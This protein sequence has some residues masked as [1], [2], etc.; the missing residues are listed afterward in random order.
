M[1]TCSPLNA[2]TNGTVT[3]ND[4][5][6]D[7]GNLKFETQA[8]YSCDTGFSLVGDHIRT[9]T[10]DGNS[11]SGVFDGVPPTCERKR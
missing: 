8:T 9:C 5:E 6:D 10:G 3:Y 1:I 11:T 4:V 2:L 7:S